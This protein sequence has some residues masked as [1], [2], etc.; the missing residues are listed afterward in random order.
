VAIEAEVIV[1]LS[2][3]EPSKKLYK[4]LMKLELFAKCKE[5]GAAV[6]LEP[7]HE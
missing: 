4:G 6:D 2:L 3:G 5:F 1:N 7:Q